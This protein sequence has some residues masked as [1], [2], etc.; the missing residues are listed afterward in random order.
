M[1]SYPHVLSTSTLLQDLLS[2]LPSF[3]A[4]VVDEHRS[5]VGGQTLLK[6]R[7]K[8]FDLVLDGPNP[9]LKMYNADLEPSEAF[10]AW[11]HEHRIMIRAALKREED[12]LV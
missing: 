2:E 10:L 8:G 1:L 7:Q 4:Q 12:S 6:V 9:V 3:A 11:V 5:T